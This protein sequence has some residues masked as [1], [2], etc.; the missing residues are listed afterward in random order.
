[1]QS[2]ICSLHI[3]EHIVPSVNNSRT[4][5]FAIQLS[6]AAADIIEGHDDTMTI[7]QKGTDVEV[8]FEVQRLDEHGR[9]AE[10]NRRYEQARAERADR[11]KGKQGPSQCAFST[12]CP[13]AT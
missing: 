4:G 13:S 8:E 5:P 11:D 7:F 1:M 3:I 12:I 10:S 2:T 6:E 9:T